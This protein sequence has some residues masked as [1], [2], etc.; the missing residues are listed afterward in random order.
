MAGP[1]SPDQ[2]LSALRAEGLKVVE[3]KSWRTHRRPAS[4]GTFGPINGVMLH[5]TVTSGTASSVELCYNGHSALPGPLCHGVIAKDGTVYLVSAGRANHA[6]KGDSGVLRQ[7][8]AESFDR[9]K[10]LTP[11]KADTD[12]N[13]HFYGFECVNL[14]DGKDP[15]PA[16][17]RDAMVRASAAILRAYGGPAKGWTARSVIGHKEWQPGKIDP[18]TGVGGVDVAPPVVRALI[19]ERLAHP[20]S[21]SP[22]GKEPEQPAK[23]TQPKPTTP[24]KETPVALSDAD[25]KRIADAVW[26]VMAKSDGVYLAPTDAPDYS[27][28]V[29]DKGHYWSGRQV[30]ADLVRRVRD[31]QKAVAALGAA[32]KKES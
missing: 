30:M 4:T 13:R 15:W 14:G 18:R 28:T 8:Q 22:G 27:P 21:W 19:D 23:P 5:H 6:G 31:I 32:Q 7:V 12:G 11:G 10:T 17:Q 16:T 9:G 2:L 1:L 25:V 29:T 24:P 20:A 26:T 3:H